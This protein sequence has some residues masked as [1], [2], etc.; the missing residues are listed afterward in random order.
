MTE[1]KEIPVTITCEEA[2]RVAVK[3]TDAR[4]DSSPTDRLC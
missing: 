4:D 1:T 2:T 3:F